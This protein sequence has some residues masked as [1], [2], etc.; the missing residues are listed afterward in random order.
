MHTIFHRIVKN[1][2]ELRLGFVPQTGQ[3]KQIRAVTLVAGGWVGVTDL[4]QGHKILTA[5]ATAGAKISNS[6]F[7]CYEFQI[8]LLG[9][10]KLNMLI[11]GAKH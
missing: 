2:Q 11:L 7:V 6:S 9:E 1:L 8:Y 5:T 3:E 10:E 4:P